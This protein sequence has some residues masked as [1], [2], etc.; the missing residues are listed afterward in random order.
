[1][2]ESNKSFFYERNT[3]QELVQKQQQALDIADELLTLKTQLV[4]I[5]DKE[6]QFYKLQNIKLRKI[7]K[8]LIISF[9]ITL[10]SSIIGLIF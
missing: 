1:M 5:C 6:T 2:S 7:L 3:L 8:I 9:A 10:V 4:E